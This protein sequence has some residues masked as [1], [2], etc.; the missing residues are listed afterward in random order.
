M[1]LLIERYW[2]KTVFV[3]FVLWCDDW[4]RQDYS[5]GLDFG[6]LIGIDRTTVLVWNLV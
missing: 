2:Q 3:W 1:G 6:A 5:S 4:Y